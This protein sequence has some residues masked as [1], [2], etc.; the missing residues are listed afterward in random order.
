M[1]EYNHDD[2]VALHFYTPEGYISPYRFMKLWPHWNV[3]D[4]DKLDDLISRE[5]EYCGDVYL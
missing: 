2:H 5:D 1:A 3:N 4:K